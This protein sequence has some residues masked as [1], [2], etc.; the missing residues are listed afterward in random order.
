MERGRKR[1]RC[2]WACVLV[3]PVWLQADSEGDSACRGVQRDA[4]RYDGV[5]IASI[6]R[7]QG[8]CRLA[9]AEPVRTTEARLG[10]DAQARESSYD[11][12]VALSD[13][14]YT[15]PREE[16]LTRGVVRET[17]NQLKRPMR[18]AF[19]DQFRESIAM[20]FDHYREGMALIGSLAWGDD[21]HPWRFHY[22][23]AD[24]AWFERYD[25]EWDD[26]RLI[27]WG[28]F[29]VTDRA[30]ID[31]D[32]S[33][34]GFTRLWEEGFEDL[35]LAPGPPPLEPPRPL[36][37]GSRVRFRRD[38][39]FRVSGGKIVKTFY[40]KPTKE[41][42]ESLL[43]AGRYASLRLGLDFYTDILKRRY[44]RTDVQVRLYPSGKWVSF[45]SMSF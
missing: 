1:P 42:G 21:W 44:L 7:P 19:Q 17:V 8:T 40:E 31:V 35:Q 11:L 14:P 26:V 32:T 16:R 23:S 37:V 36:L 18:R 12:Y 28:P 5:G 9:K 4:R 10:V 15:S 43:Q 33:L 13:R 41:W 34:A 25:P 27:V 39:K 45:L 29:T 6:P 22:H 24:T 38:L 30:A 2:A 20:S 3:L